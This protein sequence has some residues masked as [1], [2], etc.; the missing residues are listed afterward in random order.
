MESGLSRKI[1]ILGIFPFS[2]KSFIWYKNPLSSFQRKSRYHQCS[3]FFNNFFYCSFQFQVGLRIILMQPVSVSAFYDHK[4]GFAYNFRGIDKR[5]RRIAQI[6]GK[7]QFLFFVSFPNSSEL[8][9][10]IIA[11]P[12]IC[13]AS[14]NKTFIPPI[15]KLSL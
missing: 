13:P 3:L 9:I 6:A 8:V 12:N 14:L 7:N 15:S 10:S 11:E 1:L 5:F 4:T 2:T